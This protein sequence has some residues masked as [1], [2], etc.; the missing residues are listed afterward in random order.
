MFNVCLLWTW[1]LHVFWAM[2]CHI[3]R[4]VCNVFLWSMWWLAQVCKVALI[5]LLISGLRILLSLCPVNIFMPCILVATEWS[6]P[7]LSMISKDDFEILLCSIHP[8]LCLQLWST[9][10]WLNLS[11]FCYKMFLADC[12]RVNQFCRACCSW[13][14]HAMR[15]FFPCLASM[16]C[17]LAGCMFSL[18]C[19]ALWWVLRARKHAYLISVLPCSSF[20]LSLNLLTIIAM[21]TWLPLYFLIPFGL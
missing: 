10:A 20:L 17:L 2:P 7:L 21:F 12:L 14:M 18:S 8:C 19:N 6:M 15:L 5:M 9:L 16:P 11:Y 13:S 1:A 4:G 3:Y